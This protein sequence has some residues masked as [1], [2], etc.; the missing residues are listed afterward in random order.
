MSNLRYGDPGEVGMDAGRI[1]NLRGLGAKWVETNQVASLTMVVARRGAVVLHEAFGRLGPEP[2]DP[3]LPLDAIYC[4][5]S[6]TKLITATLVMQLVEDGLLGLNRPV[7]EYLPEVSG[8]GT[9]AVMVHHLLTH[10]SGFKA[11]GLTAHAA[12]KIAAGHLSASDPPE[13]LGAWGLREVW[14]APL[15]ASPGSQMEYHNIN[16]AMLTEIVERLGGRPSAQLAVERVFEPLGLQDAWFV[17]LDPAKTHRYVRRAA[18][19]VYAPLN[20]IDRP[21][22]LGW[23][24]ANA[25]ALDIARFGQAFLDGGRPILT[26]GSVD[27]MIRDQIPG[28]EAV[29][30][31]ERFGG[32]G[33]GY[34]WG[35]QLQKKAMNHP[36]LLSP[37]AFG[38][39]GAGGVCL[40]V[41]PE[42]DLVLAYLC[43]ETQAKSRTDFKRWTFDLFANAVVAAIEE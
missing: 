30:G 4:L 42:H 12:A 5:A 35:I 40:F 6:I 14:D 25:T 3:R 26:A 31:N 1:A 9:E 16:F 34:G 20:E 23:A 36:S 24:S 22:A 37:R 43:V 11:V 7:R 13:R 15:S 32:A 2:D 21:R 41:D 39:S 18:D 28:I 8:P 29:L 33:W 27:A 17:G 19:N 10:S 38:H